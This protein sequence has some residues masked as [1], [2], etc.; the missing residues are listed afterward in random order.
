LSTVQLKVKNLISEG[1]EV[2]L[3]PWGENY[4]LPGKGGTLAVELS[5]ETSE[6]FEIV[7]DNRQSSLR[8]ELWAPTGAL[9]TRIDTG[10]A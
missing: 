3:E 10:G 2:I 5:G 6:A 4:G 9:L 1:I 8:I 7:V